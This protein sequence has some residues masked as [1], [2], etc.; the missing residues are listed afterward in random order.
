MRGIACRCRWHRRSSD[1]RDHVVGAGVGVRWRGVYSVGV[2]WCAARRVEGAGRVWQRHE[3][4]DQ[5]R[6]GSGGRGIERRGRYAGDTWEIRGRSIESGH[7]LDMARGPS[8]PRCLW[9]C[10]AARLGWYRAAG[11]WVPCH[12]CTRRTRRPERARGG[13]AAQRTQLRHEAHIFVPSY[14]AT[15]CAEMMSRS[16][17]FGGSNLHPRPA[18]TQTHRYRAPPTSSSLV[19]TAS[20]VPHSTRNSSA[21]NLAR[22]KCAAGRSAPCGDAP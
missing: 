18:A 14:R 13:S 22:P 5:G 8:F 21:H 17:S 16:A 20:I 11:S 9:S 10:T 19:K 2:G 15:Y 6:R 3:R 4:D 1:A 12:A 7:G